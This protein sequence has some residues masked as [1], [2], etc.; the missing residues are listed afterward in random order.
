[1]INLSFYSLISGLGS[2]GTFVMNSPNDLDWDSGFLGMIPKNKLIKITNA[3]PRV[4]IAFALLF[5]V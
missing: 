4:I 1:M 3:C 5:L 2:W